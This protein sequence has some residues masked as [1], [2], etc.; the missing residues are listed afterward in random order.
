MQ[1]ELSRDEAQF[2]VTLL[3]R[4]LMEMGLSEADDERACDIQ[5]RLADLLES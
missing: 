2:L 5:D 1:V 4:G 3:G